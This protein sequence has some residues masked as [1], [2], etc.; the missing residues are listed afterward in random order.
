MPFFSLKQNIE[1]GYLII[2]MKKM[3]NTITFTF[4]DVTTYLNES[5]DDLRRVGFSLN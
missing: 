3:N 5:E 1:N 4:Y 2:Q